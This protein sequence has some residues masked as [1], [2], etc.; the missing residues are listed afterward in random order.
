MA[1]TLV[2]ASGS[3]EDKYRELLP[4]LAA[5][6]AGET[7]LTARLANASAALKATFDWLWVGFYLVR[8]TQDAEALVLAPFQG[9]IA[10]FRIAHGRGVCGAAWARNETLL[11]P[12]VEAFP[13]HI[14]CSSLSRSEVVVPLR[15]AAGRV[16]G[17]LDVDSV[18]LG[19]F[20][21]VDQAWL[22]KLAALVIEDGR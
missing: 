17:V 6:L 14:A 2:I 5:L 1:E 9:P 16:I 12:D 7:D 18:R 21:E 10:C 15:D 20:D 22:E 8:E 4:Q 19:D 11:V 13:G 3:K